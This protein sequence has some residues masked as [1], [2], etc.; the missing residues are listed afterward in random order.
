MDSPD[1]ARAVQGAPKESGIFLK[2]SFLKIDFLN[3]KF[4]IA[5]GLEVL[6]NKIDKEVE[7]KYVF[8]GLVYC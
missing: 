8:F 5:H 1:L 2:I 4:I 7:E 6:F 3:I